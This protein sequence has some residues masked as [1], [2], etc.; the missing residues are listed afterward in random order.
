MNQLNPDFR[1]FF[2]ELAQNN[3]TTWFDENRK[4]YERAVKVPFQQF[5]AHMINRIRA[6]E[7]GLSIQPADAISRINRDI[8]FSK[9]KTPYNTHLSANISP[10][11]KK[12]K[13]YPGFYFQL[14]TGD[15]EIYGGAYALE[16]AALEKL[17]Q[18]IATDVKTF[19][20]VCNN[21]AFR[22]QFGELQGD[23]QKRL[24]PPW[25]ERV[26]EEPKLAMKQFYFSCTL[27]SALTDQ[28][29]L[30]DALMKAYTACFEMNA[31]LRGAFS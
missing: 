24:T 22:K 25:S 17:R 27:P 31:F 8:R 11:G 19:Q 3:N 20:A 26:A 16:P 1:Q 4:R 6:Y 29:R 21:P 13:A 7:P 12:N 5:V 14:G 23:V 2:I 15:I 30:D 9:D 18:H 10:Y 28:P